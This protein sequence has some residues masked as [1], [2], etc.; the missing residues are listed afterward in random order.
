MSDQ[1]LEVKV[2]TPG[3]ADGARSVEAL[4]VATDKVGEAG[5]RAGKGAT[6]LNQ[7]LSEAKKSGDS[8]KGTFDQVGRSG[9]N[10]QKVFGGLQQASSGGIAG[11]VGMITAARGLFGVLRGLVAGPVGLLITGVTALV[12]VLVSLRQGTDSTATSLEEAGKKSDEL[13][14]K[15]Q[16]LTAETNK[17]FE[18]QVE[19]GKKLV[20][21]YD[22]LLGRMDKAQQ[23]AAKQ[24]GLNQEKELSGIELARKQALAKAT[25]DEARDQVNSSFDAKAGAVRNRYEAAA[26]ENKGLDAELRRNNAR[27]AIASARGLVRDAQAKAQDATN[28]DIL[29][30]E[31][32]RRAREAVIQATGDEIPRAARVL[33]DT[34]AAAKETAAVKE[35]ALANVTKVTISADQAI[36]K[37]EEEIDESQATTEGLPTEQKTFENKKAAEAIKLAPTRSSEPARFRSRDPGDISAELERAGSDRISERGAPLGGSKAA[38]GREDDLRAELDAANAERENYYRATA[39]AASADRLNAAREREKLR[40]SKVRLNEFRP[41]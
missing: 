23:R 32:V 25:T 18:S 26:L 12:A 6:F 30:Q 22:E 33:D 21:Q 2:T 7:G 40:K 10:V 20:A 28:A 17:G 14:A 3:A 1:K 38:R 24:A 31:S 13:T 39:E 4:A 16:S 41:Q 29:S 36:T 35:A 5:Q 9:E 34:Q 15:I 27:D 37:A 8:L 19:A 11:L